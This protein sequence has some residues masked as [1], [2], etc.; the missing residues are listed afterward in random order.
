MH[1]MAGKKVA[2][3]DSS[4]GQKVLPIDMRGEPEHRQRESLA[5]P[6]NVLVNR[7]IAGVPAVLILFLPVIWIKIK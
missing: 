6:G 2:V 7:L 4:N 3:C 5:L 1:R